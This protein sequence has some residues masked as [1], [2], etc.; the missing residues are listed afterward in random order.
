MKAERVLLLIK[1]LEDHERK[2]VSDVDGSL[3]PEERS[4]WK[5][6]FPEVSDRVWDYMTGQGED[7]SEYRDGLP[8]NRHKRRRVAMA[9]GV[10]VHLFSGRLSKEWQDWNPGN[11]IEVLTLDVPT[12]IL[13]LQR[14]G[15]TCGIWPS[16]RRSSR[17]SPPCRTVSRLLEKSPGPPRLRGRIFERFGYQDLEEMGKQKA[18]N[19]TALFLKQVG[20]FLKF[21]ECRTIRII[22]AG[23]LLESPMDPAHYDA[24]ANDSASFWAWPE[25]QQVL[26]DHAHQGMSLIEFD[27]GALQHPRRKPTGMLTNLKELHQLQGLRSDIIGEAL[28]EELAERLQMTSSWSTWAPRLREVIRMA[29]KVHMDQ[30]S[31]GNAKLAKVSDDHQWQEHL[32][33]DHVPFRN[34]CRICLEQMGRGLPHRRRHQAR[35]AAYTMSVDLAG[36]FK[37]A[38][39]TIEP[40]PNAGMLLLRL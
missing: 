7:P 33:Q 1:E 6:K 23:F 22:L 27:Q 12:K 11:G 21:E 13:T 35:S 2:K 14:F 17:S 38:A 8:W 32:R 37:K 26:Q 20:L 39:D 19:D 36:P 30:E 24:R 16:T 25:T 4:W 29:L 10:V 34:D 28:P 15:L 18:N 40:R 9:R 31:K 3:R 5:T